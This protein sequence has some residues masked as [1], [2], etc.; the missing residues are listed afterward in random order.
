MDISKYRSRDDKFYERLFKESF[1]VSH[2]EKWGALAFENMDGWV[3]H[4]DLL[5]YMEER[6]WVYVDVDVI[7]SNDGSGSLSELI[8]RKK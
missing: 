3:N 2:D 6:G 7:T 1:F 8:F 4:I 5:S